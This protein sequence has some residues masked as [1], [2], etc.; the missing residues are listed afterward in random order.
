MRSAITKLSCELA[1]KIL[2][3]WLL[4]L[5]SLADDEPNSPFGAG[6]VNGLMIE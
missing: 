1:A 4:V 2:A 3:I 5:V 6:V